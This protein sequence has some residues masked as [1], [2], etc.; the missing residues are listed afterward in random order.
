MC[1]SATASFVTAGV[2]GLAGAAATGRARERRALPLAATPL[3]FALQQAVEGLLW[4]TLPIAPGGSGSTGLA[5]AFLFLA[6][7]FWPVY[8][9]VAVLLIEP[10]RTRR[11]VM[12]ACLAAGAA[13]AATLLW[14]MLA[15]PPG[16]AIVNGHIV[17]A[18]E[19]RYSYLVGLA[20]LAATGLP[21]LLSSHRTVAI[22]GAIVLVGSATAYVFYWEAFVSVWCFFA[23]AASAAILGHFEWSRRR[24][25]H[26]LNPRTP[27]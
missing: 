8:V 19:P 24:S 20:Y 22:V 7:V 26:A 18:T 21:L 15:A 6:E 3:F 1:F 11:R 16:A 27:T 23:A 17:Y 12:L 4:L 2:T 9:P 13:V 5:L 10:D 25:T 14:R